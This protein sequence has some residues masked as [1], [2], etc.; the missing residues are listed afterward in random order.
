M[1]YPYKED[2]PTGLD[3]GNSET[4]D[5]TST[6]DDKL[7]YDVTT[8]G[9]LEFIVRDNPSTPYQLEYFTHSSLNPND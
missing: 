9:K 4:I 3:I 1:R 8:G 5:L 6:Y 7:N 2:R